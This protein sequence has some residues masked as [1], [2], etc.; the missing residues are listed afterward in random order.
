MDKPSKQ[1]NTLFS[2]SIF[3]VI[4]KS[5]IYQSYHYTKLYTNITFGDF[6]I[7]NLALLHIEIQIM[8][9][10]QTQWRKSVMAVCLWYV[11]SGVLLAGFISPWILLIIHTRGGVTCRAD[12]AFSEAWDITNRHRNSADNDSRIMIYSTFY[13][14]LSDIALFPPDILWFY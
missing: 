9:P 3:C 4:F 1:E 8:K 11:E 2:L 7:K 10:E 5:L 13:Q 12:R 6:L 14:I